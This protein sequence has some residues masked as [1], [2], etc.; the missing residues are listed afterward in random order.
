[1]YTLFES[2]LDGHFWDNHNRKIS[3]FKLE[4][5][6]DVI[7]DEMIWRLGFVLKYARKRY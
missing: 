5:Y 4:S 7:M 1:M 6:T 2:W 3:W